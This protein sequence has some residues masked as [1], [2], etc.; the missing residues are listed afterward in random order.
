MRWRALC[1]SRSAYPRPRASRSSRLP[2]ARR[3]PSWDDDRERVRPAPLVRRQV[4]HDGG[5]VALVQVALQA[6][7]V[8]ESVDLDADRSVTVLRGGVGGSGTAPVPGA[9]PRESGRQSEAATAATPTTGARPGRAAAARSPRRPGRVR[10]DVGA[11]IQ[12]GAVTGGCMSVVGVAG[13]PRFRL[14]SM[15]RFRAGDCR[16]T[17]GGNHKNAHRGCFAQR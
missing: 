7:R 16:V 9:V 5:D 15:R 1:R 10:P 8:M 11:Q 12:S 3:A 6:F 4:S 2:R 17:G 13:L 14:V